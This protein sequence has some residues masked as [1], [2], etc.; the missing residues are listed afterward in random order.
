MNAERDDARIEALLKGAATV[1]PSEFLDQRMEALFRRRGLGVRVWTHGLSF[2]AGLLV[3]GMVLLPG[4]RKGTAATAP[5]GEGRGETAA[6]VEEEPVEE[7]FVAQA[8]Q[9]VEEL[10]GVVDGVPVRLQRISDEY[11]LYPAGEK[12]GEP[13]G[14]LIMPAVYTLSSESAY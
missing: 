5:A 12:G 14:Q 8:R 1:G 4:W 2:A 11:V 3:A 9:S 13:A 6:A 7:Y 10:P